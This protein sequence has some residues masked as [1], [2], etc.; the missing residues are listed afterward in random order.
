METDPWIY[1]L[2]RRQ[3]LKVDSSPSRTF[4]LLMMTP[5][6]PFCLAAV[7]LVFLLG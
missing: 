3:K 4:Q 6:I 1:Q 7:G 2:P 5:V